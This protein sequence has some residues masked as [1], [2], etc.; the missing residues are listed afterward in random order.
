MKAFEVYSYSTIYT[1]DGGAI[2]PTVSIS[3]FKNR[4]DAE[5]KLKQLNSKLATELKENDYLIVG[6]RFIEGYGISEIEIL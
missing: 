5:D 6:G 3:F 1:G 4:K 2:T